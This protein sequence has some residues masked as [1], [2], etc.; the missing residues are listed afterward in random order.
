[1]IIQPFLIRL[2]KFSK[3][4]FV[5]NDVLDSFNLYCCRSNNNEWSTSTGKSDKPVSLIPLSMNRE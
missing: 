5:I 1:M 4:S 3:S 2:K